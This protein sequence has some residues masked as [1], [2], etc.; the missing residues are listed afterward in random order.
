M[1]STS[2]F[3]DITKFSDFRWKNADVSRTQGEGVS[4]DS[5]I[6]WIFFRYGIT[7][8]SFIIVG[9]LWQILGMGPFCYPPSVSS[10]KSAHPELGSNVWETTL[11]RSQSLHLYLHQHNKIFI[12]HHLQQYMLTFQ[13]HFLVH[14]PV[15][16][17]AFSWQKS[18]ERLH[19]SQP[20]KLVI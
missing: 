18:L 5:Y 14:F 7:M 12:L 3:L 6:F 16:C 2:V 20:L 19:I 1:Q 11:S 15:H 17:H 9:Y 13:D 10:P 4:R 8:P